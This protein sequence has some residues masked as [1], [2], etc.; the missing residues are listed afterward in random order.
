[1]RSCAYQVKNRSFLSTEFLSLCLSDVL[2][3]R[4]CGMETEQSIFAVKSYVLISQREARESEQFSQA[5]VNSRLA[6]LS[7]VCVDLQLS[8]LIPLTSINGSPLPIRSR[9]ALHHSLI[10]AEFIR[11]HESLYAKSI[12]V[13]GFPCPCWPIYPQYIRA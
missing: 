11:T 13:R 7:S 1:M 6:K 3:T 9:S 12:S 5:R 4:V 8:Y 2:V 10:H